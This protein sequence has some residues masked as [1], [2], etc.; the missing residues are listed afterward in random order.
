MA[1]SKRHTALFHLDYKEVRPIQSSRLPA[2]PPDVEYACQHAFKKLI[3]LGDGSVRRP[4]KMQFTIRTVGKL[5]NVVLCRRCK[6]KSD[7]CKEIHGSDMHLFSAVRKSS[8][9]ELRRQPMPPASLRA[10]AGK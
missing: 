7:E 9:D 6:E 1:R 3:K 5:R 4:T 10:Q 8:P 2:L